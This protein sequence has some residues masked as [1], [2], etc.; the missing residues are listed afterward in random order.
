MDIVGIW[1]GRK[2]WYNKSKHQL[3]IEPLCRMCKERGIIEPARVADHMIPHRG[4]PN[5]FWLGELQ[6]LCVDHHNKT[7]Q[8]IEVRGYSSEIGV[9]GFPVDKNHPFNKSKSVLI[10]DSAILRKK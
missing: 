2:A 7:K 3:K 8:Q 9:D 1:Y 4:D 5:L 10:S 6:S